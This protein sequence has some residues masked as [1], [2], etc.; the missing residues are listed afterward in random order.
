MGATGAGCPQIVAFAVLPQVLPDLISFTLYRFE[1]NNRAAAV[2]GLIGA[3]GIGY[4]MNTSFRTFQYI[5]GSS[6][7]PRAD[8]PSYGR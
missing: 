8:S 4:L 6:H 1:T 7:C 3:G 5:G 2:L